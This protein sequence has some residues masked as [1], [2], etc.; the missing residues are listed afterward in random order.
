MPPMERGKRTDVDQSEYLPH[1]FVA[2][3]H[4]QRAVTVRMRMLYYLN[5]R[6]AR[7]RLTA[8]APPLLC[9]CVVAGVNA[10]ALGPLGMDSALA[11]DLSFLD[12]GVV[13]GPP[14]DDDGSGF[15]TSANAEQLG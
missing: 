10:W 14:L 15:F 5:D 9:T 3:R 11:L 12:G 8:A 1:K 4:R 7:R 13:A 2:V 6:S